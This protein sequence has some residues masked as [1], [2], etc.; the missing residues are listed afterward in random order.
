[1]S[2]PATLFDLGHDVHRLYTQKAKA[3]DCGFSH[4]DTDKVVQG[5]IYVH[6]SLVF[7]KVFCSN[8]LFNGLKKM[9]PAAVGL[10][11]EANELPLDNLRITLINKEGLIYA[12]PYTTNDSYSK[13]V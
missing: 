12:I 6:D 10:S 9:W 3:I 8:C 7:S 11:L 13:G 1:M 5:V 2:E 4:W